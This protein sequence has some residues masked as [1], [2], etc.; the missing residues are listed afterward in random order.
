MG[1]VFLKEMVKDKLNI[2][3][4]DDHTER[5]IERMMEDAEIELNHILGAE[6]DYST[7]GMERS[8]YLNYCAYIWNGVKEEFKKAYRSDIYMIRHKNEVK[9]NEAEGENLQ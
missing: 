9:A 2:T 7:P 8:L 5:K 4:Q 3:W 1:N 6:A